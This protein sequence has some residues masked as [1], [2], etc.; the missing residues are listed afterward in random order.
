M[1]VFVLVLVICCAVGSVQEVDNISCPLSRMYKV[2]SQ[3][4]PV[5]ES[6]CSGSGMCPRPYLL[7]QYG[8]I[9]RQH[10]GLT[11]GR[12]DFISHTLAKHEQGT[13]LSKQATH[14]KEA[15]ARQVIRPLLMQTGWPARTH[16]ACVYCTQ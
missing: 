15:T 3:F 12:T 8:I 6:E 5:S 7:E 11:E 1:I 4:Q 14:C 10:T 9:F 2:L 13:S 16:R